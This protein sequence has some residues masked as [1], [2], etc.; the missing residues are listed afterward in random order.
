[1]SDILVRGIPRSLHVVIQKY[2]KDHGLSVNQLLVQWINSTAE[3][4]ETDQEKE[5]RQQEAFKRIGEI[6]EE[7]RKKYGKQEDSV[8]IIHEMRE[9]RMRRYDSW[10][11]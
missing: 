8:K 10:I 3:R 11:K 9:E 4:V 5:Q 6:R 2:A 1:M 7:I